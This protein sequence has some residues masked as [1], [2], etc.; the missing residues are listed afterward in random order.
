M[1]FFPH[2]VLAALGLLAVTSTASADP[3][4]LFPVATEVEALAEA[5]G[6]LAVDLKDD[7]SADDLRS[8][9]ASF[10]L[11]F[12][13]SS[14]WSRDHTKVELAAV[15]PSRLVDLV[16]RLRGDPRV[17]DAEPLGLMFASFVPNDPLYAEKQWHITRV[18]AESAWEY[19][20]G[21]GV[22]VAVIDTGVACFDKEP[23]SRGTDLAGTRCT[24]G[25]N[26]VNDAEP[27]FDDHGHGTHVAGTIAQTTHNG[28][29]A[30]GLAHCATLMPIKVL[31][32][33]G[34]GTTAHVADGIRYAADHGAQVMNLSLG[35]ASGSRILERAVKYA[36]KKGVLVVAA[37]GNSGGAVGYPAAYA[38]VVAVSATDSNDRV[39]WFSSRGT[40]V[41]LAAPGVSVTQQTVCDGGKN[42]CEVFGTFSGTSMASP[43]VAG[44][45]ALL[46]GLGV[47]E[48]RALRATME[49]TAISKGEPTL[50]GAGLV[51]IAGAARDIHWHRFA[52]RALALLALGAIVARRIGSKGGTVV[53]GALTVVGAL[54]GAVGLIP[55]APLLHLRGLTGPVQIV[56]ELLMRPLGEWDLAW[57][58]EVHRY[59]PLGS[60]L[61]TVVL[62][63]FLFGVRSLRGFTGGLALGT[64]AFL[65]HL[66]VAG[67]VAF[68]GGTFLLRGFCVANV[69]LCLWIARVALD[70][71]K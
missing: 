27:A 3:A 33:R 61:P 18:G 30:A 16:A 43:H 55:F 50:Y 45:A 46:L 20:C 60:A 48:P 52:W 37:A 57:S 6:I 36:Q 21:R 26:F 69:L 34:W 62:T 51:D 15:D 5:A 63:A 4:P 32:A 7:T 54:L 41:V 64:S 47:T 39:A 44:G 71:K 35:G 14:L 13:A 68:V 56:T 8:L 66:A 28:K 49:R 42:H 17:E 29:G 65:T 59:L 9:E 12:R 11:T 25:Y 53:R 70:A 40:E 19:G 38:G 1:T 22:T 10:G 31:T 23:F 2:S 24:G 58:A 67:D